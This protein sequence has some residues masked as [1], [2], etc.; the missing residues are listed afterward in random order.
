MVGK[1]PIVIRMLMNTVIFG[2]KRFEWTDSLQLATLD[3][4][5]RGKSLYAYI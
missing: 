4:T 5:P 3:L 1:T 2:E